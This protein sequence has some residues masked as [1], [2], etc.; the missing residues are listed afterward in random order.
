VQFVSD[1]VV[2]LRDA[3]IDLIK[4]V[5]E[6]QKLRQSVLAGTASVAAATEAEAVEE[7]ADLPYLFEHMPKAFDRSVAGLARVAEIVQSMKIFAHPDSQEEASVDLNQAIESTLTIARNEY[8]Y[9][10]DVDTD[11]GEL[12]AIVC[13]AGEINQVVLNIIVNAAHAIGDAIEGT[14]VKGRISVRTRVDGEHVVI[15]ISDTGG[16]IPEAIR[17][18]IFDPFFTTK[19]VGKGTGQGLA[20][21]RSVVVDKHKGELTMESEIGKGTTFFIRL[22]IAG[23]KPLVDAAVAA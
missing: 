9:V 21:A 17:E 14:E 10:A 11:F 16:G 23:C 20:I 5:T 18:R 2:F 22:P 3:S 1:S 13:H 12:P 8:K 7:A 19:E 15:T 4:V 6:L